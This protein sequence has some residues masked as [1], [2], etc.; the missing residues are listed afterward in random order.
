M[1]A[2]YRGGRQAEALRVYGEAR[3]RLVDELGLEPG[4]ALRELEGRVLA[5]DPTLDAPADPASHRAGGRGVD[6]QPSRAAHEL[7]RTRG[8]HRAVATIAW[9]TIA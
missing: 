4:P 6:R 5:Q 7:R 9:P 3:E 8:R 2:L 1:L